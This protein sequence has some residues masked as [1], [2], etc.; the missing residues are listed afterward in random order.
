MASM[1]AHTNFR[2]VFGSMAPLLDPMTAEHPGPCFGYTFKKCRHHIRCSG[3]LS[4]ERCFPWTMSF[5][6]SSTTNRLVLKNSWNSLTSV[7]SEPTRRFVRFWMS[8]AMARKSG[9]GSLPMPS[10]TRTSVGP[11]WSSCIKWRA[12]GGGG[13]GMRSIGWCRPIHCFYEREREREREREEGGRGLWRGVV[14]VRAFLFE[15][16]GFMPNMQWY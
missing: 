1:K 5:Q 2:W 15:L 6:T 13:G 11:C 4:G 14:C 8:W 7:E 16:P 10:T 9:S 12:R 3:R